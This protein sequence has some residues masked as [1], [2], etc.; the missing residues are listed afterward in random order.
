MIQQT[1]TLQ[2]EQWLMQRL[3]DHGA[4]TLDSGV[5]MPE[6]RRERVRRTILELNLAHVIVGSKDRK[7]MRYAEAFQ[8][9][10]GVALG[11]GVSLETFAKT[12]VSEL[13][14]P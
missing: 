9:L 11:E 10:Y 13:T 3:R 7:P 4:G 6:E 5:T 1:L 14:Q 2:N 12:V 8:R